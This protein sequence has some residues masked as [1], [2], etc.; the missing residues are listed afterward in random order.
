MKKVL[1]L[2]VAV[3]LLATS[4]EVEPACE[5]QEQTYSYSYDIPSGTKTMINVEFE[6][7]YCTDEV[8]ETEIPNTSND[9]QLVRYYKITCN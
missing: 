1:L 2:L 4:C 7:V 6:S 3:T 8:E 9:V 5:C